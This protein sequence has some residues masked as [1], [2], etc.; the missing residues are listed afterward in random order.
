[1]SRLTLLTAKGGM[2]QAGG[3]NWG[4]SPTAH[5]CNND[6]YI[7][8]HLKT[9]RSN[10]LFFSPIL[11]NSN[12]IL[13]FEW[14]DGIVMNGKFEGTQVDSQNNL[15][16]PKQISSCPHKD[17]LGKYIRK[18][19]GLNLNTF[20]TLADLQNYGRTHIDITHI[21][22]TRYFLDFHV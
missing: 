5:V 18:R 13:T 20:I 11:N 3:L 19:L 14:D 9:I 10:R 22:G 15:T 12:T 4:F 1:M 7:P 6:A 8:I 21:S 16:Y 2:H 17:I